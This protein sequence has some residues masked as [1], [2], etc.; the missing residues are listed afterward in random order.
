[1]CETGVIIVS[2]GQLGVGGKGKNTQMC[3]LELSVSMGIL[4]GCK[5]QEQE[6]F[7]LFISMKS[8][9][10]FLCVYFPI[11]CGI[12]AFNYDIKPLKWP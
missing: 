1:M 8:S 11:L 2:G 4:S 7:I 9:N 10:I 6:S 3:T 5:L 12:R